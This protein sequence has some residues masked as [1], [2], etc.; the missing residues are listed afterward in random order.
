MAAGE[1]TPIVEGAQPASMRTLET[2]GVEGNTI[3]AMVP[4]AI[5]DQVLFSQQR[6]PTKSPWEKVAEGVRP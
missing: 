1:E 4:G 6:T 3:L 2:S 5:E